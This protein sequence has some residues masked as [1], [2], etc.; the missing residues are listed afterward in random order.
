MADDDPTVEQEVR[1]GGSEP[2]EVNP[3][4]FHDVQVALSRLVGKA[5]QLLGNCTT[6]LAEC[7]MHIR[8]K[9]DGG[10][11]INR[12]QSG[13]WEGRCMGAGLQQNLGKDW[14]P[15]VWKQMAG[16]SPNKVYEKV[17]ECSMNRV[18]KDRKRKATE[19]AKESRR[20]SKYARTDDTTAARRVYNRHDQGITPED[21]SSDIPEDHLVELMHG[22]YNTKVAVTKE[23]A[24][25]IELTTKN[26][27]DNQQWILERRLRVTASRIGSIVKMKKTTKKSKKVEE[28]LY[29]T[30]RGNAATRY[31]SAKETESIEEYITFQRMRGHDK[32]CVSKC[33]FI[34]STANPWLGASPDGFVYDP[35]D[36]YPH[37][38]IEIKNPYRDRENS[39]ADA[40]SS[41]GFCLEKK[42]DTLK[43]KVRHA[44][45]FQIQC[46][47]YCTDRNW[48]DFVI[49]TNKDIY[50]ERVQ[51]NPE[52]WQQHLRTAKVFYF[53]SLLA[54]LACPRHRNGG[55]REHVNF[56]P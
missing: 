1:Q 12:S 30:F 6:N 47:L 5:D 54:E 11:V 18:G 44:Y 56:T 40:C 39:L 16:A 50:V 37:G 41:S 15:K 22:F 29:S 31:G 34:V 32:L 53:S 38:I 10:K 21:I 7:W 35:D 4:L 43:L 46:Q 36:T 8:T 19:E 17:A 48:C 49:R 9:F 13:S 14:G 20:K 26:Q 3:K 33:G 25:Q 24:I 52:W 55:I 42:N 27:A 45:Y 28:L 51:R 2:I 23:K